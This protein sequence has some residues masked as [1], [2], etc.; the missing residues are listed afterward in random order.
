MMIHSNT[1]DSRMS[2]TKQ[3]HRIARTVKRACA[4]GLS[5]L[6]VAGTSLFFMTNSAKAAACAPPATDYGTASSTVTVGSAASYSIWSQMF[7][8]DTTNNSYLLEVDGTNCFVVGDSGIAPNTWAWVNYQNG[9]SASK[10]TLNLTAGNHTVKMIGR[11]PSV[12]LGRI[13]FLSDAGCVPAGTGSNCTIAE[14]TTPP[15]VGV[16]AP[17]AG[18]SVSG[19]AN[20]A[21]NATD[22]TGVLKVEFYINGT[23]A[24]TST[25]A[26]YTYA[27]NTKTSA[28]GPANLIAKAYDA[29]GNATTS[30]TVQVT[31]N[32]TTP[33]D[34]QAP[35]VPATITATAEAYNKV[36]VKWSASTDNVGVTGYV[37]SRNNVP[38]ANVV[39]TQYTD[40]N[41]LPGTRYT[42]QVSAYDA[43]KN[44]SAASSVTTVTT[45]TASTTD[46]QAPS[47]PTQLRAQ[48]T[49]ENQINLSWRAATDNI[50]VAAYD[51]YRS[52]GDGNAQA[53]KI[54]TVT[55]TGYGDTSLTA[56][57]KYNYFVKARDAAGNVSSESNTDSEI[58]QGKPSKQRFSTLKGTVK[59]NGSKKSRPTVTI[60]YNGHRHVFTANSRGR[61]TIPRLPV[62]Q[63]DVTYSARGAKAQTITVQV[64][65]GKATIQNVTL[66]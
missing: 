25:T 62:G 27:W 61:Y 39:G 19:T 41:V 20:I 31:V 33:G 3:P 6:L 64:V 50:G 21:A 48:A 24:S 7:V 13:L 54:A 17:S 60:R 65:A 43:A 1:K 40:N 56:S 10:V 16:T 32:N 11:E 63:Y 55:S 53:S 14:D 58:T 44:S 26:P 47:A 66:H 38:L 22:N 37:L 42:Y 9:N 35:S 34:T 2:Q 28:N 59:Y 23:L 30:E 15:T 29:A 4:L 36:T 57:T 51:V 12:Q 49:S 18:A 45:P 5:A 52:Q 8:P 46:T